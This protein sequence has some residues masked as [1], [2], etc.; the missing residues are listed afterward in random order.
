MI[1]STVG[2]GFFLSCFVTGVYLDSAASTI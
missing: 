2:N 1:I